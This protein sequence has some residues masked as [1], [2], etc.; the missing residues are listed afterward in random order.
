[1]EVTEKNLKQVELA[2][3]FLRS[4]G[5]VE[6]HVRYHGSVARIEVADDDFEKIAK[7]R[8]KIA[9]KFK[10]I[11]F[12]FVALDLQGFRS[13]ALNEILTEEQKQKNR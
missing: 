1:M 10:G 8:R 4:L 2:E 7:N 3:E 6:F 13:G 5:F 11:G 9:D 12:K